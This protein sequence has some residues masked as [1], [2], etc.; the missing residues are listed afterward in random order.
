MIVI[1]FLCV[2][3]F[4]NCMA[5]E[6][7]F[8][9]THEYQRELMPRFEPSEAASKFEP[10]QNLFP[11]NAGEVAPELSQKQK[12]AFLECRNILHASYLDIPTLKYILEDP[13]LV[14]AVLAYTAHFAF[15]N[16]FLQ[17]FFFSSLMW[18]KHDIYAFL[19]EKKIDLANIRSII[20]ETPGQFVRRI[21]NIEN[22]N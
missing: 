10:L 13:I 17:L 21:N 18:E 7:S 1:Y 6:K 19:L 22:K 3:F 12:T 9:A 2:Y 20:N 4:S 16:E 11:R 8:T 15:R 14:E 5:M